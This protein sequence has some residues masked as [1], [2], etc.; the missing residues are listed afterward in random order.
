MEQG[1]EAGGINLEELRLGQDFAEQVNVQKALVTVPVRKPPKHSFVRVRGG[2]E[3]GLPTRLLD[4]KED[5]EMYLVARPLWEAT[6]AETIPVQLATA[7]DRQNVLFLWPLRLPDER[8]NPWHLSALEASER[9]KRKW[10]RVQANMHLG[11]YDVYEAQDD[12]GEPAWPDV[13][14]EQILQIAFKKNYI[15]SYDHLVLKRLRGEAS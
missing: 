11:A 3:W 5:R 13:G 12:L 8:G 7:I 10:V 1:G 9:A 6:A 2:Q 4:F 15:D 14:F